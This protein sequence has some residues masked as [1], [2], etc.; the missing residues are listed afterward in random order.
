MAYLISYPFLPS[1]AVTTK[2]PNIELKGNGELQIR[3][4]I[5]ARDFDQVKIRGE[6]EFLSAHLSIFAV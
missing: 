1:G 6:Q 3:L 5:G 2:I 4:K